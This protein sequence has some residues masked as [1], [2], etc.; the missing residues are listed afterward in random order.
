MTSQEL[1]KDLISV[2]GLRNVILFKKCEEPILNDVLE[3]YALSTFNRVQVLDGI[4]RV[5]DRFDEDSLRLELRGEHGRFIIRSIGA[6][7]YLACVTGENLNVPLLELALE[8]LNKFAADN[9]AEIISVFKTE[10]AVNSYANNI[11]SSIA[12]YSS[13]K[14]FQTVNL[15]EEQNSPRPKEIKSVGSINNGL[16]PNTV[17]FKSYQDLSESF[18]EVTSVAVKFLGKS[19]VANYWKQTQP[20]ILKGAFE[21]S[22]DGTV[23]PIKNKENIS[24]DEMMAGANWM[25]AFINRCEKIIIDTP[26]EKRV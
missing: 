3:D 21:I 12:S 15:I 22:L 16:Q 14:S 2:P 17:K 23:K 19:V 24:T 25:A 10:E 8:Q 9:P 20:E 26:L 1:F 4:N 11:P 6:E 13:V 5:I 7:M 18:C